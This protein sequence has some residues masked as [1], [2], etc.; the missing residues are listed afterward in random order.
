VLQQWTFLEHYLRLRV[1]E[2]EDYLEV[3]VILVEAEGYLK[4][5]DYFE[6][7]VI[8]VEAEGCLEVA[9]ALLEVVY[10]LLLYQF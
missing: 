7:V 9:L 2:V 3:V 5:A 10:M 8:L 4:A 1:L 6:V